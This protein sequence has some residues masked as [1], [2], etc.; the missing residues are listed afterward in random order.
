[1]IVSPTHEHI[2][3]LSIFISSNRLCVT[4]A[5]PT[6]PKLVNATLEVRPRAYLR[7]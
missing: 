7:Q 1:M 6:P 4:R 5:V 3:V 2:V